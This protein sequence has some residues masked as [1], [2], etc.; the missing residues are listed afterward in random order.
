MS[1]QQAILPRSPFRA[2]QDPDD[3]NEMEQD[4]KKSE[5]VGLDDFMADLEMEQAQ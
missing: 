2:G 5:D 4:H 3:D 1:N